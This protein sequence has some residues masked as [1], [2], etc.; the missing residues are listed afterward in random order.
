MLQK[1][2]SLISPGEVHVNI[3]FAAPPPPQKKK[4]NM[5]GSAKLLSSEELFPSYHKT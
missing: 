4:K 3:V 1:S 2:A 5:T